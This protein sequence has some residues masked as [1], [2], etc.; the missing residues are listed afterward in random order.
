MAV[1]AGEDLLRDDFEP[2]ARIVRIVVAVAVGGLLLAAVGN[3]LLGHQ[4]SA[5]VLALGA[6]LG[7]AAYGYSHAG[8][9]AAAVV[10]LS[11]TLDIVV[12]L[13]LVVSEA[14]FHDIAVSLYPCLMLVASLVL[15]RRG[16]LLL[17]SATVMLGTLAYGLEL[18]G[19]TRSTS[20]ASTG[21]TEL[22][23]FLAIVIGVG[24]LGRVIAEALFAAFRQSQRAALEDALTGLPNRR[25]FEERAAMILDPVKSREALHGLFLVDLDHFKKVNHALGRE[26]GD[27]LLRAV[28]ERLVRATGEGSLVCRLG[29]DEFVVL[30]Q[31]M[32]AGEEV[33]ALAAS[34]AQVFHKPFHVG[35]REVVM[36]ACVGFARHPQDARESSVLILRADEALREAKRRG[37]AQLAGYEDRIGSRV[38]SMLR[39]ET[40]LRE[41]LKSGRLFVQYQ[42]ILTARA[43]RVVGF[44]ALVRLRAATGE[45]WMPGRFIQVAEESGLILDLGRWVIEKVAAQLAEWRAAGLVLLPVSINVSP[46]QLYDGE[47]AAM[48]LACARG[49]DLDPSLFVVELTETGLMESSRDAV[50]ELAGIRARGFTV[51]LDDFG[52]GYSSLGNLSALHVD[53]VKIDRAFLQNVPGDKQACALFTAIVQLAHSLSLPV[54]AE[55]VQSHG[56]LAFVELTGCN[57]LQGV[58][59]WPPLNADDAREL[60]VAEN[61]GQTPNQEEA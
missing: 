5:I 34:I 40:E 47:F 46:I 16:F 32:Q 56:M 52:A 33:E 48:L 22:L 45:T 43:H 59:L 36:T 24:A 11:V 60:L 37:A 10:L 8:Q 58:A 30:S 1:K 53:R 23:G 57:L 39:V 12:T 44:E 31:P 38:A 9:N 26:A 51:A 41:A 7:V 6:V 42:P 27:Q 49:H 19:L 15:S 13:L 35:E 29:G 61:Q 4:L 25:L 14:G 2:M 17:G 21:L 20:A 28:G 50:Q 54:V 18:A 3:A 55:G